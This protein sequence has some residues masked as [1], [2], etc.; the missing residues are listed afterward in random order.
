MW[1]GV[2]SME[3]KTLYPYVKARCGEKNGES[4]EKTNPVKSSDSM[5]LQWTERHN[6]R[7]QL[8][9]HPRDEG[10]LVIEVW[11]WDRWHHHLFLGGV[12]RRV[13]DLRNSTRSPVVLLTL[14]WW[15]Y[16]NARGPAQVC[17]QPRRNHRGE[18]PHLQVWQTRARR[19][20]CR[21]CT[22]AC[23]LQALRAVSSLLM[24]SL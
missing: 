8:Q 24:H 1:A 2:H 22:R 23:S 5:Q 13:C 4:F 20:M 16:R 6:N 9:R 17:G 11:N 19:G 15:H 12:Q 10:V 18:A 14:G 21:I 7:L 3:T